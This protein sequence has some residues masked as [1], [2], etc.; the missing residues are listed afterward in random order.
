M[1]LVTLCRI[2]VHSSDTGNTG[3]TKYAVIAPKFA[4]GSMGDQCLEHFCSESRTSL[5]CQKVREIPEY[6]GVHLTCREN[7]MLPIAAANQSAYFSFSTANYSQK[8]HKKHS[9]RAVAH[10]IR[11]FHWALHH[12]ISELVLTPPPPRLRIF[13]FVISPP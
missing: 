3:L 11:R 4:G 6:G 9:I 10:G 8:L 7:C 13:C 1:T 12:Q 2:L 5:Q